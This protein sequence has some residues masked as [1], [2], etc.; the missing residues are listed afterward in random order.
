MTDINVLTMTGRVVRDAEIKHGSSG[1][2][3]CLFSVATNKSTKKGGE[4]TTE[5]HFFD[6]VIFGRLAEAIVK[7]LNK[8]TGVT[9]S[10][11][12]HQE[13]W[14]GREGNNRTAVKIYVSDI[15]VQSRSENTGKRDPEWGTGG[16]DDDLPF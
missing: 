12:L 11:S 9:L 4:W 1:T 13:R 7:R 5:G 3:V 8:G 10:G 6:C 16:Q 15:V 14:Q 2:A